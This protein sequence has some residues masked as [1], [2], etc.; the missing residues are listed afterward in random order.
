MGEAR[1]IR[2]GRRQ[3][4]ST[5]SQKIE[6]RCV[7]LRGV[8]RNWLYPLESPRCQESKSSLGPNCDDISWNTQQIGD[9]ACRDHIQCIGK[10]HSWRKGPPT[11]LK[12]FNP[13]WFLSKGN[14]GTKNGSETEEM[15]IQRL[16]HLGIHPIFRHQPQTLLQMPRST[17]W[18]EPGI[19]IPWGYARVWPIQMHLWCLQIT[20]RLSTGTPMQIKWHMRTSFHTNIKGHNSIQSRN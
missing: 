20:I 2:S 17:C 1:R 13:E 5:E 3:G 7:A 18:Q 12:I 4:R 10:D 19:A 15:A 8:A 16:P 11:H 14:A 9:W 6:W